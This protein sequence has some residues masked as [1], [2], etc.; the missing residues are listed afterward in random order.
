VYICVPGLMHGSSDLLSNVHHVPCTFGR[1]VV[2]CCPYTL[3]LPTSR[4]ARQWVI[5]NG[6]NLCKWL[7]T[8]GPSSSENEGGLDGGG[9]GWIG[10]EWVEERSC[11]R[12][13]LV[14]RF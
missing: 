1:E 12:E 14:Q 3:G 10:D 5:K 9:E 7:G 2:L 8:V 4:E 6:A 13:Q 11:H